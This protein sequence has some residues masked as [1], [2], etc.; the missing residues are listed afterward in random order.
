MACKNCKALEDEIVKKDEYILGL[1]AIKGYERI[2]A[3]MELLERAENV[4]TMTIKVC[5]IDSEDIHLWNKWLS[6]YK[7]IKDG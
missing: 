7:E 4:I 5:D 3:L 1:R 6:D 2:E